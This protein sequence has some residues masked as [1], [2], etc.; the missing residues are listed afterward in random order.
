MPKE[1]WSTDLSPTTL[2]SWPHCLDVGPGVQPVSGG[3]YP[4]WWMVGTG[5]GGWEGYTGTPPVHSQDTIFSIYL[6]LRPTYG[7][8]KAILSNLVRFLR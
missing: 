5:V 2:F 3:V 4:G 6:R 7:Q 8:M 1:S